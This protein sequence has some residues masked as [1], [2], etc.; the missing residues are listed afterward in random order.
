ME[1]HKGRKKRAKDVPHKSTSGTRGGRRGKRGKRKRPNVAAEEEED[2][3]AT[4]EGDAVG[5]EGEEEAEENSMSSMGSEV[6]MSEEENSE[7]KDSIRQLAVVCRDLP[8]SLQQ[9]SGFGICI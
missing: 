4:L 3:V 1:E 7:I 6:Q 8:P 5:E 2:G 9:G